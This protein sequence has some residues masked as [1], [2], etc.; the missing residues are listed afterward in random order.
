MALKIFTGFMPELMENILNNLNDESYSLYSCALVSQ[1]WCKMSIPVLWQDPF[2][3]D[4]NPLFIS[5]YISSL[6][7]DEKFI[8]KKSGINVVSSKTLF[9]YASFIKILDIF[10]LENMVE[11]WIKSQLADSKSYC[12]PLKFHIRDLL[13][14]LFIESG[15]T[16][17]KLDIY[18]SNNKIPPTIFFSLGQNV[19][20]FSQLQ[21]LT[22]CICVL[23]YFD[24]ENVSS[25][26]T[27]SQEN[28]TALLKILTKIA[29]KIS[30]LKIDE[31]FPSYS[32]QVFHALVSIIKSQKQ[33]REFH[34]IGMD[35]PKKFHGIILA[36]ESQKQSLREVIIED[37]DYNAE[38]K[39][40]MN[41]ENLETIRVRFCN[42]E[43][44][45]KMLDYKITTLEIT[46]FEFKIDASNIVLILEKSGALLQRLKLKS[47]MILEQSLLLETLKS[48]CPNLTYLN[49]SDIVFSTQLLDLIDN[50]KKLQFLTLSCIDATLVEEQIIQFT[51]S[52]PFTLQYLDLCS[53]SVN[54]N[55]DILLNHCN[56]PL[57]KLLIGGHIYEEKYIKALIE[58]C[59]RNITLKYLGA[60]LYTKDRY[61]KVKEYVT[62]LPHDHLIVD[63]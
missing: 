31:F 15:A 29:T 7:E 5:K 34:I 36:L 43:R 58:F 13:L 39:T 21:D 60:D 32:P 42:D 16:L 11:K 40:L 20:F 2:S 37:C 4:Q 17:R 24:I 6:D 3:F 23:S 12:S 49:I 1:Y 10:R 61:I 27:M 51:K 8:L 44:M 54:S 59:K 56:A 33:L 25:L 22:L 14:K 63:C 28:V 35:N 9:E 55:I 38:F 48:F 19:Q 53:N 30:V 62:V 57:R 26:L 18:F 50:L 45:L 46:T 52:L 41:C 47:E